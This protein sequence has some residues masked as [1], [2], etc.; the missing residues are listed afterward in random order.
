MLWVVG[1]PLTIFMVC[2]AITPPTWGLYLQPVCTS[3]TASLGTSKLRLP[4]PS[5]TYTKTF[6]RF[7]SLTTTFSAVFEPWQLASWLMSILAGFGAVPPNL[8]MPLTLAAVA[9]S[10]G[11]AA[12]AAA[13]VAAGCS[14]AVSFLPQPARK[15]I[16]S[17]ADR[18]HIASDFLSFILFLPL[19]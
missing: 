7:P 18:L 8:T 13:G 19:L 5:L 2:P 11:V 1:S 3:S 14:S 4:R 17:R 9:G 12:G 16:P 10:I 15:A 6:S